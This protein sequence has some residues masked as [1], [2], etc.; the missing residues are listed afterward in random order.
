MLGLVFGKARNKIQDPAK[1]HRLIVK[2][3]DREEWMTLDADVKGDRRWWRSWRP[4]RARPSAIPLMERAAP[5]SPIRPHPEL[6]AVSS[7]SSSSSATPSA[8]HSRSCAHWLPMRHWAAS[9]WAW[10]SA[11]HSRSAAW[12]ASG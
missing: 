4:N 12:A 6:R 3:L 1:L 2:L 7:S 10:A 8:A 5:C 9:P 11:S